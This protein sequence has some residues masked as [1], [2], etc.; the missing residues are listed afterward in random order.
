VYLSNYSALLIYKRF[1]SLLCRSSLTT[2]T[3]ILRKTYISLLLTLSAQLAALPESAFEAELPEMDVFYLDE[4]EALRGHLSE[5]VGGWTAAEQG[6]V[7][8]GWARL[9]AVSRKMWR[10]EL[11]DLG[12]EEEEDEDEQGEYAPVVVE[13]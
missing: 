10:W 8:E 11:E 5:V 4:I 1:L 3:T 12:D 13:T 2:A 7:R 6:K 9:K